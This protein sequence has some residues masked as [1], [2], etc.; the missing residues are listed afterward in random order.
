MTAVH[1]N[2]ING[3]W[4]QP[5]GTVPNINPSDITDTIGEFANGTAAD[6]DEAV[7]A[8]KEVL[9]AW[10]RTVP[11]ERHNILMKIAR[12]IYAR[13]NELGELLS[14]EEGKVRTEGIGEV[15]RAAQIFEF[16]AADSIRLGGE[17]FP[18]VRPGIGV[19]VTREA[20]G[21]IG[22]ITPWNFPISI[23]AWKIAPALAYGNCVIMKP[24]ELV[25]ASA[26]AL[27]EII[28]EAGVPAG[29]FNLV[30][31]KGS[32][33]GQRIL[34]HPDISAITFTGSVQT[35]RRVAATAIGGKTMKKLQL[36]MGGKNPLVVLDDADLD[37]AADIAVNGAFYAT[38]QRCTASE[39]IIV[40][41]GIHDNFIAAVTSKLEGLRIGHALDE[42]SQIGP[43]VDR[44]QY[45][46]N[47]SFVELGIRE[48]ARLAFGGTPLKRETE[49]FYMSPALFVDAQPD[50]RIATDEVF[51]PF[52]AVIRVKNYEEALAIANDTE[53]GLSAGICTTSLKHATHFKR[54]ADVGVVDVNLP[55]SG[56]DFHVPFGGRK[57]SSYGPREQGTYAR[58][59]F[60]QV[61]T[62]YT[63]A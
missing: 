9:P 48:G 32:V 34:E 35:G 53:F 24:A 58:E 28:V 54:N 12:A 37:I 50:M 15:V 41:E 22:M 26:R 61:K 17:V 42:T 33:V 62:A 14:R 7:A 4:I 20:V 39:R 6:V 2:L 11:Y 40:T 49:G 60:T 36:E 43:V 27:A 31:G 5:T 21:I 55:T 18:S 29:V 59:F 44:R 30:M 57:A 13:A 1:G 10:S 3:K 63:R 56:V 52:A 47:L 16:F 46:Q 45:E 51:G 19:E 38:G 23:P 8:A 25:P